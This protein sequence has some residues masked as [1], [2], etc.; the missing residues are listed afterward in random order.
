MPNIDGGHY[1]LTTLLPIKT[2]PFVTSDGVSRL[3]VQMVR[4]ALFRMPT[5]KQ[6]EE[7]KD[8]KDNSP[9]ASNLRTHFAR[10][11][12]IDDCVDNGRNPENALAAALKGHNP[13][14]AQPVD[15]LNAPYL[16]FSA[17]FDADPGGLNS[18]LEELYATV[19]DELRKPFRHCVG[20]DEV[21]DPKSFRRYVKRC[22]IETTMPFNDYWI[23]DPKLASLSI[24]AVLAPIVLAALAA[25]GPAVAWLSG[26]GGWPWGWI[27]LAA[28][29]A[30]LLLILGAYRVVL[31]LGSRPFPTAPHS[32]LK[33]ILKALYLQPRFLRFAIDMQGK[34]DAAIR[35]AFRS[36][37]DEYK[38]DKVDSPTQ[39][40]GVISS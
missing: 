40:P 25:L 38:P 23:D 20:F 9:F 33:S 22:Q 18:Y 35:A 11:V 31:W 7:T 36:F 37:V 10:L 6:S 32:D 39:S 2:T 5:A 16:L 17:D 21:K 34:D 29:A 8:S 12:V 14:A 15:Q 1:F 26:R 13:L 3:P 24:M 28:T 30:T 19:G 27:A 4:E